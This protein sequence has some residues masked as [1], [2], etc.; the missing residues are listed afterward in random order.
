[1]KRL[2]PLSTLPVLEAAA[3]HGSFKRAAEELNVTHAAVSHQIRSLEGHLGVTLFAR[4]G[5][6]VTLTHEGERLASVVRTSLDNLSDAIEELSPAARERTLK[7]S[8]LQSFG[9]RWLMA[10]LSGFVEK[11]PE[12][13]M[14]IETSNRLANFTTDGVDIAV[15]YG[16][17]PWAGLHSEFLAGDTYF[18]VASPQFRRGK[19]PRKPADLKG[20]PLFRADAEQWGLW[21]GALGVSV[22]LTFTGVDYHDIGLSL[23]QAIAGAGIAMARRSVVVDDL[24]S[25]RLVKL[26]DFEVPSPWGYHL[27]CLPKHANGKKVHAFREWLKAA[28]DWQ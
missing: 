16:T 17:G 25:G 5:R 14:S 13:E 8:V 3:R 15:R 12:Y 20:L 1:M 4:N 2:P 28:I 23:Q 11:H 21:L 26:F 9:A 7:I 18:P 22:K 10:R 6:R 27:V 19:L 24:N